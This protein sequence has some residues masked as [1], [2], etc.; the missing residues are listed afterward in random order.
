MKHFIVFLTFFL[1]CFRVQAAEDCKKAISTDAVLFQQFSFG[2]EF[3]CV[4]ESSSVHD[5]A[6]LSFYSENVSGSK[7][8]SSNEKLIS[9]EDARDGVN[10]PDVTKLKSGAY[11]ILW[12]YPNGVDV[13]NL[14]LSTGVLY[15]DDATKELRLHPFGGDGEVRLLTLVNDS[16]AP[17][18]LNFSNINAS[19]IFDKNSLRLKGEATDLRISVE[20]AFL[21]SDAAENSKTKSYL[22]KG[23]VVKVAEYKSGF[24]KA[25]YKMKNGKYLI[26]WVSL[27]SVI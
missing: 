14:A 5:N 20:K 6:I 13:I 18:T 25:S 7:L 16:I 11:Q 4:Y 3:A 8:I 22:I 21:Y 9:L 27:S 2:A 10:L 26:R 19:E 1:F 24:L 15:F 12:D 17:A 23:D